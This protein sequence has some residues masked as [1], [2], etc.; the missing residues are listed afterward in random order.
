METLKTWLAGGVLTGAMALL[1]PGARR[2]AGATFGALL[3][4]IYAWIF[5]TMPA[6]LDCSRLPQDRQE[7]ARAEVKTIIAAM[8]RLEEILLPDEGLGAR[9]KMRVTLGLVSLGL[10]GALAALVSDMV[11]DAVKELN[12]Q[13]ASA[14]TTY[15]AP[16]A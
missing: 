8:V 3:K 13:A 6:K 11:D 5:V 12:A 2:A 15:D 9:K 14:L 7:K 16:Q 4:R 1:A 10:P